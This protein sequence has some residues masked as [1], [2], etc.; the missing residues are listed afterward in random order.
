MYKI[1][2]VLVPVDFSSFS[3][4]ALAFARGLGAHPP[5][6]HLAHVLEPWR[7][8]LRRA[9]FPY[10]ALGEDD[11]EFEH[12]LLEQARHSLLDYL[13]V[14]LERDK[15]IA[16]LTLEYGAI[17]PVLSARVRSVGPDLVVMGAF[18][19]DGVQPNML[20]STAEQLL[21][22][23]QSAVLLVRNYDLFPQV[24]H[25]VVGVDLSANAVDI[26]TH[27]LGFALTVG[28]TLEL[29]YVLP[30][31]LAQDTNKLLAGALDFDAARVLGR[32]R[33]RIEALFERMIDQ[34][35]V[36]F[37]TQQSARELLSARKVIVGD[38]A[39][40]LVDHADRVNADLIIVGAHNTSTPSTRQLGRVAWAV[41]RTSPTH[42]L[43]VP[44]SREVSLLSSE[45]Y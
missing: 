45:D 10:A 39:R 36:T 23:S 42:V 37:P 33:Q 20:G 41:A 7:P 6:V 14:N 31:P 4:A 5:R 3:R 25:M 29:V 2:Q 28:A 1:E 18:G 17:R 9:L 38:P 15:Y 21:H 35:Q 24:K 8:Y 16:G 44:P 26:A 43:V 13:K 27:A 32:L 12:E 19:E 30:D 34:V 22:A 40:A 11:V